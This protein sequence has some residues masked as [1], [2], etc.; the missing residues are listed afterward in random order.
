MKN[1]IYA[2]TK[3]REDKHVDINF[4]Y[5]TNSRLFTIKQGADKRVVE[6]VTKKLKELHLDTSKCVFTEIGSKVYL[7][8]IKNIASRKEFIEL[9][10]YLS[11]ASIMSN[12]E[13][14]VFTDGN[15]IYTTD[16]LISLIKS[17]NK[18]GFDLGSANKSAI[19]AVFRSEVRRYCK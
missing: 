5:S 3:E 4:L 10:G 2:V 8:G 1:G 7:T 14:Y 9:L 6:K 18:F 12:V 16:R 11:K 17:E 19:Q 15:L 13:L